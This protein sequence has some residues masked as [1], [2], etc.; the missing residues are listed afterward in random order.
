MCS[1]FFLLKVTK[2]REERQVAGKI[3]NV[4]EEGNASLEEEIEMFRLGQY[5]EE[6]PQP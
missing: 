4:V 2:A 6:E 3:V 5:E 1:N